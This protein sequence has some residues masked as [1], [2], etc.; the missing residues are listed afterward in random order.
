[1]ASINGF[2]ATGQA[3]SATTGPAV[4]SINV[5]SDG[6]NAN[7]VTLYH[8]NAAVAGKE[9]AAFSFPASSVT[10][11]QVIVFKHPLSC[12]DG[13]WAVVTGSGGGGYVSY[14]GGD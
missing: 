1:M 8:G 6:V 10:G 11:P 7:T 3:V 2:S 5:G 9:I 4:Y 13:V 14:E 12:P